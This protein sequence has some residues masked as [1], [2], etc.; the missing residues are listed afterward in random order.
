MALWLFQDGSLQENHPYGLG[1]I[2][3]GILALSHILNRYEFA[4]L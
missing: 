2:L 3:V 1:F 4:H